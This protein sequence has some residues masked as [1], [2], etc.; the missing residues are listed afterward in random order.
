VHHDII[1]FVIDGDFSGDLLVGEVHPNKKDLL[2]YIGF[3]IGIQLIILTISKQC[4]S[5]VM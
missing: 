4:I 1:E 2:M 3:I 5:M